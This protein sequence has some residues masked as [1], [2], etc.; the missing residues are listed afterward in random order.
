MRKSAMDNENSESLLNLQG[1][2]NNNIYKLKCC[3][4]I[5]SHSLFMLGGFGLA[6]LLY[7]KGELDCPY[8]EGSN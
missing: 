2:K 5:L 4:A 7:Q 3:C 1:E 8:G 6:V